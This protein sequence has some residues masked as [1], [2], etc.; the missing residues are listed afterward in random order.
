MAVNSGGAAGPPATDRQVFVYDG[1]CGFC[2]RCAEFAQRRVRGP[3]A[4]RPFQRLDLAAL[5]LTEHQCGQAV[6]WV[7]PGEPVVAGPD[8]IARLLRSGR[9]GWRPVGWLLG[10]TPV[11]WVAWP[12]YRLVSRHRHRMPGGTAACALPRDGGAIG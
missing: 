2:T 7:A 11:R 10:L 3:A 9:P 5:G 6:Q 8:A 4:I 12:V 1:D